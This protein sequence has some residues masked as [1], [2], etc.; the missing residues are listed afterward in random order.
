MKISQKLGLIFFLLFFSGCSHVFY[1]PTR[2]HFLD[3]RKQFKLEY[4][5]ITFKS[6]D[7]TRLHGWFFKAKAKEVKGT[8][9][10]FHGN[11][12]NISTHFFSLVWLIDHGYNLFTFDYRGYGKSDGYAFQEGV[13]E[14]ALAA[15]DQGLDL[16]N[17]NGGGK[18]VVY[19]QSLG[20][21][22]ALRALPDWK[23]QKK[24]SLFVLDSTFA[25]YQDVA[26]HKISHSWLL[27]W[28]SPLTFVVISDKYA[29]DE[30]MDKVRNPV[31]VIVGQKDEVIPQKFGK[32]IYKG[33]KTE[34][35]WLW[36]LPDGRHID[37]Y[38]H[39]GGMYRGPFLKLLDQLPPT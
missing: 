19:G 20:G 17:N 31:L 30:V 14:D 37:A 11:A 2:K 6:K 9:V 23:E 12:E 4:D 1:Q 26:F 38:H 21:N 13:Y 22:I 8:I 27:F 7:G 10:Q 16:R 29:A 3:P 32:I 35:K 5:D 34:K 15:L 25:S 33:L 28:L 24:V 18:F 36:K 39:A